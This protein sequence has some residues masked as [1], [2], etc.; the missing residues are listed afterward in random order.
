MLD[1]NPKTL[2]IL[3]KWLADNDIPQTAENI[4]IA[5]KKYKEKNNDK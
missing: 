5:Y 4:K 1:I 2:Q 3:L